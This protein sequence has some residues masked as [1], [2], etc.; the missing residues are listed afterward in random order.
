MT[1]LIFQG[2]GIFCFYSSGLFQGHFIDKENNK[3]PFSIAGQHV[4][5]YVDE[6]HNDC[7]EKDEFYKTLIQPHNNTESIALVLRRQKDNDASGL[8][9]HEHELKENNGYQLQF[10]THQFINGEKALE[11]KSKYFNNY[12]KGDVSVCI[13]DIQFELLEI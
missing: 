1:T 12:D 11:L 8:F 6:L 10:E 13:G 4:P 7:M 5:H 3:S 9:S 2:L